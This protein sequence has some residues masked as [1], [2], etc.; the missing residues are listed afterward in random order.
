MSDD[1]LIFNIEECKK[2]LKENDLK[3]IA[4]LK[5]LIRER[6][7]IEEKNEATSAEDKIREKIEFARRMLEMFDNINL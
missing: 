3:Y 5:E 4:E 1:K 7:S 6:L 2:M